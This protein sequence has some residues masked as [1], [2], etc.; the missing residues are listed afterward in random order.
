MKSDTHHDLII[1]G[2]GIAGGI[3]ASLM[4]Q[5]GFN[6]A[7]VEARITDPAKPD[8]RVF[9]ITRASEMIFRRAGIW[10]KLAQ[11]PMGHFREMHVWDAHGRGSI[12]F[13]SK[14]LSEPTLGYI[15]ENQ[16]I[17]NALREKLGQ[18]P[19]L[20]WYCPAQVENLNQRH[21]NAEILLDTGKRLTAR[22][23]IGADGASSRIRE[24][25]GIRNKTHDYQQTAVVCSVKTQTAHQD[26]ARQRFLSTGPL[27]FLPLT[28]PHT[29]SI[30]WSTNPSQAEYLLNCGEK[31][32]HLQLEQAFDSTLGA[33]L[34]TTQR[35]SFPLSRAHASNYVAQRLALIGDAAHRVHPLAGQGANMG[36]LDAAA[37][38]ELLCQTERDIGYSSTL[39]KYERWRKGENLAVIMAMDGFK[40]LFGSS[41]TALR[42]SRNA[43]LNLTDALTPVKRMIMRR[44]MGLTGDL[45]TLAHNPES[46]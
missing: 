9:A 6:V 32:F 33:V 19:H 11:Q 17:Q 43:G 22:L 5:N 34:E 42:W 4:A 23:I 41:N 18:F 38:A 31:E 15:I 44:A 1:A 20:T 24:L 45:P 16:R 25:A 14:A 40:Y 39:R 37:L 13:D 2:G 26:I 12:H 27:A 7:I 28:D 46:L 36:I 21:N 3:L 35:F 29:C 8:P 10:E 30:V